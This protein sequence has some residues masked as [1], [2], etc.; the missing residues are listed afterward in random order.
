MGNKQFK[1]ESKRLLDLM[2]NS[3]YTNKEIFLRELI[4]NASDALDKLH[5]R[6]LTDKKLKFNKN[7]YKIIKLVIN[8]NKTYNSNGPN[9][10]SYT[11]FITYSSEAES[12]LAI[13]SL[14]NCTIDKHEI[15]A[16]YGTTKYCLNFLKNSICKNKDC[17]YLHKL[18]DEKDIVSR[19]QMNSDK[20]IFPQQRLMA[21]ELSKI[22]TNKKYKELYKT[23]NVNTFFPNGF[24]VYTKELVIRYIKEKNMG[25]SLNLVS[26][27][28]KIEKNVDNKKEEN[29][30][31]INKVSKS[32]NGKE[33]EEEKVKENI[34]IST[35]IITG[36]NET[37]NN[38]INGTKDLFKNY[39]NFK[40]NLN[41]LFK[42]TQKSRFSFVNQDFEGHEINQII[43]SQINDFITQQFM[44]HSIFFNEEQNRF[45]DYY[46][47]LKPNSLDSDESWSSL[48]NTYYLRGYKQDTNR[49]IDGIS[50]SYDYEFILNSSST[51]TVERFFVNYA[52]LS[53][54]STRD[55]TSNLTNCQLGQFF[56]GG[57]LGFVEGNINSTLT[58]CQVTGD[59]FGSGF[60]AAIPSV[61]VM[62][63]ENFKVAP[64]YNP[65]AGMFN[66]AQ[67]VFPDETEYY[68]SNTEGNQSSPFTDKEDGSHYI[69]TSV[70]LN[71]L[72]V[73]K[74]NAVLTL[75]GTTVGGSVYGGGDESAVVKKEY[76]DESGSTTVTIEG[77][78]QILGDVFG[79]GNNG[80]VG[81]S[82]TVNIQN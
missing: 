55:V 1:A 75:D 17:I 63:K 30:K 28:L 34:I 50:T 37:K 9:G 59:V 18:A 68:W 13:L 54:A 73:V 49:G 67:V 74:G 38:H 27:E 61:M 36:K 60:S 47:S 22:L 76:V 77:G 35:E 8:K 6:S 41:S 70:P 20:D 2:I 56:G 42:S 80:N 65:D 15:K 16:N 82:A 52:S 40:N 33:K 25:V 29:K 62:P 31:S 24:S 64:Y 32:E 45:S 11:C 51:E 44:K 39:I 21:I 23:R 3:I 72:G 12:S 79:G 78:S 4:S 48:V 69:W 26:E 46:F 53:L 19:E 71:N 14:D 57:S 66:D 81:G 43:P 5:Y 58:G 7:D 10:P